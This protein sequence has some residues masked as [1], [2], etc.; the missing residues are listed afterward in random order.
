MKL[1]LAVAMLGLFVMSIFA[2]RSE[3]V[4]VERIDVVTLPTP[5]YS[6]TREYRFV[7][8]W[9]GKKLRQTEAFWKSRLNELEYFVLRKEGTER[10][11]SGELTDNKSNGTY[12][13][14]ACGLSLFSSKHKYD[15][16]T[17]WPSFY[18]PINKKHIGEKIDRSIS[19]ETR[20]EVHCNRC[21]GHLGHVFDDGPEP[22]GLRYCINSVSLRFRPEK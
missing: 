16:E 17:G 5:A 21:G 12:Y 18:Q 7:D 15:S 14:R 2:G 10:A 13:C 6:S 9:D 20:T 3:R 11:Y 8:E 4:S 19:E 1:K 22:T